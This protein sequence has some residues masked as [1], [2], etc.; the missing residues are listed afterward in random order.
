MLCSNRLSSLRNA[1]ERTQNHHIYIYM[2]TQLRMQIF[3][4]VQ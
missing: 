2:E 4:D 1:L 3:V